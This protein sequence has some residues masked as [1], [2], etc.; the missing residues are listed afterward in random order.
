MINIISKNLFWIVLVSLIIAL[1]IVNL[2]WGWTNPSGNPP[3][4]GGS[5]YYLN[6]NVGIGTST[7]AY[8]LQVDGDVGATSFIYSSDENLKKNILPIFGA[9]DRIMQLNGVSF[10]WKENN[11]PDMG[12]IAQEVEKVFPELVHTNKINNLKSLEYGNLVA[13][14]IEAIKEQQ[15]QIQALKLEIDDLK[16]R[17]E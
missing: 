5:I 3:T 14:L 6:G 17:L 8:K 13:P 12:L 16:K 1:S 7:P 15:K 9:L 11:R 4:G 10:E 2:A